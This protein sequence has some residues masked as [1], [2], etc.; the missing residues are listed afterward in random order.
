MTKH[1]KE[2]NL[3]QAWIE[4]P[5]LAKNILL[6]VVYKFII[7]L[8]YIFVNNGAFQIWVNSDI[9][10]DAQNKWQIQG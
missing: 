5:T 9:T 1:Q 7:R 2:S 4:I 8:P 3:K 6:L 10:R